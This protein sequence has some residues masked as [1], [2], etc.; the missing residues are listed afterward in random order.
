MLRAEKEERCMLN[1]SGQRVRKAVFL[2][3]SSLRDGRRL[4]DWLEGA[5]QRVLWAHNAEEAA[6]LLH[7]ASYIECH[8]DGLLINFAL[9]DASRVSIVNQFRA[10]YPW[11]PV[12]VFAHPLDPSAELWTYARGFQFLR[13][14]L[15]SE[16]VV[17]WSRQLCV[18]V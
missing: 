5:G 17:G 11:A 2:V 9:E 16:E 1:V 14:P 13:A 4:S 12:A 18:A 6:Q 7:D 8:L 10:A 15:R 3:E